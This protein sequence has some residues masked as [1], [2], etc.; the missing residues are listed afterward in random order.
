M[1]DLKGGIANFTNKEN[2]QPDLLDD[3]DDNLDEGEGEEKEE[4]EAENLGRLHYKLDYDFNKSEVCSTTRKSININ[5]FKI[6][7]ILKTQKNVHNLW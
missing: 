4:E 3:V 2:V 1:G 6:S 7:T 5:G